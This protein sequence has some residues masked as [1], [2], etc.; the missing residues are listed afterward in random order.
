MGLVVAD[1]AH[2]VVQGHGIFAAGL[3][4]AVLRHGTRCHL[5][6][7]QGQEGPRGDIPSMDYGDYGP[8]VLQGSSLKLRELSPA[9]RAWRVRGCPLASWPF[10]SSVSGTFLDHQYLRDWG[11]VKECCPE[12]SI[13]VQSLQSLNRQ[14]RMSGSR[15]QDQ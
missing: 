12:A 13:P 9:K 10:M 2:K 4:V 11:Q 7:S 6:S 3:R 1:I 14:I 8:P 5:R 15:G